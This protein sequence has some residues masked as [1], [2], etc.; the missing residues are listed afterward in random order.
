MGCQG[1]RKRWSDSADAA[2]S[3]TFGMRRGPSRDHGQ[4]HITH[5]H[6]GPSSSESAIPPRSQGGLPV[7]LPQSPTRNPRNPATI[8]KVLTTISQT[9]LHSDAHPHTAHARQLCQIHRPPQH[10]QARPPRLPL[11]CLQRPCRQRP[12]LH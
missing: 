2:P 3:P 10:E 7:R 4:S 9:K 5:N 6:V 8:K 12:L 1:G 11:P